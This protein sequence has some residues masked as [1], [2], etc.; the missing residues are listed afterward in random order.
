MVQCANG[1]SFPSSRIALAVTRVALDLN[2]RD[3]AARHAAIAKAY[4]DA[5][6]RAHAQKLIDDSSLPDGR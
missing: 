1:F 3:E 6:T 2:R 4:G 5:E